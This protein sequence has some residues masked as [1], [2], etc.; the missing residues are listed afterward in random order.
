MMSGMSRSG[1]LWF[2]A[3]SVPALKSTL[4]L[5]VPHTSGSNSDNEFGPGFYTT[6]SL[7]HS[8]NYLRGRVGAVM[9]FKDPA[10]TGTSVWQPDLQEW[11]AWVSRWLARPLAIA[12]QPAPSEYSTAD[13][14]L[15]PIS[16]PQPD[17]ST[18]QQVPV[19]SDTT[20][21]VAVS[22][23]G[24]QKLADSLHLIIFVEAA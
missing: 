15:G 3:L 24:C 8:L 22:H 14:I 20:Q 13:F 2:R 17:R 21:L 4:A 1:Q 6:K 10:L 11:E 16:D 23:Q 7:R 12:R 5:F 18:L 19:Q 9:V